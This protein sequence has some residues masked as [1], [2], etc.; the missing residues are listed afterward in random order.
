M[1]LYSHVHLCESRRGLRLDIGFIDN[2][3]RKLVIPLNHS[4]IDNFHTFNK[5]PA[6]TLRIFQPAVSSLVVVW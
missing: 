6:H 3:S 1:K 5:S 4:A 2:F